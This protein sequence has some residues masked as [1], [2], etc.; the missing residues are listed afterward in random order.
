M[1]SERLLKGLLANNY[2]ESVLLISG[3]PSAGYNRVLLPDLLAGRCIEADL[4]PG[5][6]N[7]EPRWYEQRLNTKAIEL[8]IEHKTVSCADG[9]LV[10]W[11]KLVLATGSR[12]AT[13]DVLK[14]DCSRVQALRTLADVKALQG[15]PA[16]VERIT[17]VGG[18]LLGLE[19]AHALKLLDY[20]VT[21]VHRN[22]SLMNQQLDA[23][24][25]AQLQ[26]S[27]QAMG[28]EFRMNSEISDIS[29]EVNRVNFITLSNGTDLSTD[30][31]LVATGN[32]PNTE[33][34]V[35]AGLA[36]EHG[37][38]V[39]DQLQTTAPDVWAIGECAQQAGSVHAF[40]EPVYAQA[41]W[42][43]RHFCGSTD[44]LQLPKPNTRLKVAGIELFCASAD[45][46]HPANQTFV[47]RQPSQG[48]Y[49]RLNFTDARLTSAVLLGDVTGA[50]AVL[51]ALD[52]D[53]TEE[54]DRENLAFGVL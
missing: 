20:K 33:L 37:I 14:L 54:R 36:V 40:V 23:E 17:V 32:T 27:L 28:L 35:M 19:A 12:A 8:D 10:H 6:R 4:M 21:V 2:S 43:A 41:D 53:V 51:T 30:L 24:A 49:R 42:L 46:K 52:T 5:D 45:E 1:A 39:N 13:P 50:R 25:S 29:A 7:A 3:E 47:I 9:T 16:N 22:P 15:L 48:I 31:V 44:A 18:G 11:D 26:T 34:G 38:V